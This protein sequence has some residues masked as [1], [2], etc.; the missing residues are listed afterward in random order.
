MIGQLKKHVKSYNSQR[1]L[2]FQPGRA[3]ALNC[4]L[5]WTNIISLGNTWIKTMT[6]YFNELYQ[7]T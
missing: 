6:S 3:M 5:K 1:G 4:S 2:T 7:E